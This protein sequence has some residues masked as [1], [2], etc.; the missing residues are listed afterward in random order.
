MHFYTYNVCLYTYIHTHTHIHTYIQVAVKIGNTHP[1]LM[2][3]LEC[4]HEPS[5]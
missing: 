5:R 4:A 3:A 2:F 1:D